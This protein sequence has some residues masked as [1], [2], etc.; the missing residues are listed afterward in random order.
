M[1]LILFLVANIWSV[2]QRVLEQ[3]VAAALDK[4]LP[5]PSLVNPIPMDE[6]GYQKVG[7]LFL[8]WT[9]LKAV[10]ESINH[11][12]SKLVLPFW[13]CFLLCGIDISWRWNLYGAL[14]ASY[15]GLSRLM[16]LCWHHVCL[17]WQYLRL[18]AGAY[19]KTQELVKE[20]C[21][22]GCEEPDFEGTFLTKCACPW[23][24]AN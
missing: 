1:Q 10:V 18:L 6:G 21:A 3:R 15:T 24:S 13:N 12:R 20:L 7:D 16:R 17:T 22:L 23:T 14:V 19:E 9:L 5:I 11:M 2:L 8:W 4:L